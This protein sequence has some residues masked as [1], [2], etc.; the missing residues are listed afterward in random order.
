MQK[1]HWAYA[2]AKED[3]KRRLDEDEG[4]CHSDHA[5]QVIFEAM[6]EVAKVAWRISFDASE[7]MVRAFAW[8]DH[9][10]STLADTIE[11]AAKG[12]PKD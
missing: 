1:A 9:A 2:V 7:N 12:R 5:S 11:E 4:P 6:A 3:F 8:V 10:S